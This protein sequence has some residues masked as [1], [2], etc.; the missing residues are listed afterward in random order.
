VEFLKDYRDFQML[1]HLENGLVSTLTFVEQLLLQFLV[2]LTKLS[3]H[4]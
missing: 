1:T 2:M 3:T 4:H